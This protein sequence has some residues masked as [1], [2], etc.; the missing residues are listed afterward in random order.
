MNQ[1]IYRQLFKKNTLMS[2]WLIA[3]LLLTSCAKA[4]P[5]I[6]SGTTPEAMSSAEYTL[7]GSTALEGGEET[8][9]RSTQ[10]ICGK[11]Y[12]GLYSYEEKSEK[13]LSFSTE[14]TL[15]GEITLP[16]GNTRDLVR[17]YVDSAQNIYLAARENTETSKKTDTP[18]RLYKF[19]AEGQPCYQ[20]EF[21]GLQNYTSLDIHINDLC[22]DRDGQVYVLLPDSILLFNADGTFSGH[23]ETDQLMPQAFV[24][25]TAESDGSVCVLCRTKSG[26]YELAEANFTGKKITVIHDSLPAIDYNHAAACGESQFMFSTSDGPCLYQGETGDQTLLFSW[27]DQDILSSSVRNFGMAEDGTLILLT[28][29]THTEPQATRLMLFGP[30]VSAQ[31]PSETP[32]EIPVKDEKTVLTLAA[33]QLGYLENEAIVEFNRSNDQYRIEVVEYLS[34]NVPHTE[35]DMADARAKLEMDMA[36]DT[37]GYDIISLGNLNIVNLAEKGIL[38]DLYSYL[39]ESEV[40][41]REDFFES[42]LDAYTIDGRLV[43]IPDKVFVDAVIGKKADFGDRHGWTL[44]ELLDYGKA[45]PEASRLFASERQSSVASALLYHGSDS[46]ARMENGTISFDRETCRDVLELLK[47]HE[48]TSF[49]TSTATRLKQGES[50][51]IT[52]SIITFDRPQYLRALFNEP[53]TWLGFPD[54]EGNCRLRCIGTTQYGINSRSDCKE[55][56]WEYLEFFLSTPRADSRLPS[57]KA[58]FDE[59]AERQLTEQYR[60]DTQG[61]IILDENGVPILNSTQTSHEGGTEEIWSYTYGPIT[62]EDVDWVREMLEKGSLVLSDSS[63][64]VLY[65]S[66][67]EEGAAYFSGQK[68]EEAVIDILENRLRLYLSE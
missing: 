35:Q 8:F 37:K 12:C 49:Q 20:Q 10:I 22:A 27:L 23:I 51:L 11:I 56:A 38:E 66:T 29:E 63:N 21:T 33:I 3:A 47:A 31:T 17:W 5:D 16:L 52:S 28:D 50:L 24:S 34:T 43:S 13:I 32:E 1:N 26:S 68:S 6:E 41:N 53:V 60:R 7:L 65:Q 67:L 57:Q 30:E 4:A 55:G 40:L 45:H 9:F 46:F 42:I 39:D 18:L 36:L 44:R 54:P 15:L 14:G 64:T 2:L 61:N 48:D 59:M 19:N 62:Q 58:L 25:G